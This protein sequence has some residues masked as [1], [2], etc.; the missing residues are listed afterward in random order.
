MDKS[1][2]TWD[3][4]RDAVVLI[5]GQQKL[6]PELLAMGRPL[7]VIVIPDSIPGFLGALRPPLGVW[8]IGPVRLGYSRGPEKIP[9]K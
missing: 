8:I 4:R 5:G 2:E 1:K 9:K 7:H 3:V 6:M